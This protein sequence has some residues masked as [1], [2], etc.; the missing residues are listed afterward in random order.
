MP[1]LIL[2]PGLLCDQRLWKSQIAA[3]EHDSEISVGAITHGSTIQEMAADVLENA[4]A[5]FSLAGFSLGSQVAL[6]IVKIAGDRVE[7]LALLSATHG[8]LLPAAETA[9]RRAIERIKQGQ[10]E[11]YLDEAYPSYFAG[12]EAC[13]ER[14]KQIFVSMAQVVGQ[15]AG[16]RQMRALL[17][18]GTPFSHLDRIDC[19]TV[20]IG[21]R[22]DLRTTPEAHRQLAKEI[23]GSD[24]AIIDGAAHFTPIEQA[25]QVSNILRGWITS[26]CTKNTKFKKS[27][28]GTMQ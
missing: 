27:L 16:L 10:F 1:S 4:P 19:P 20:I 22:N 24:L 26:T 25:R 28:I 9:I 11:R 2:I 3:L 13:G 8:G 23:P 7:R 15:E 17:A 14:L 5:S 18:I 6:E 12:H 21:G